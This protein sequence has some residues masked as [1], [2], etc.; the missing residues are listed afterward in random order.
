MY[1][2]IQ[3]GCIKKC[4]EVVG[5]R[6]SEWISNT[7]Q[8]FFTKVKNSMIDIKDLLK[9]SDYVLINIC[10]IRILSLCLLFCDVTQ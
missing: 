6:L 10:V 1:K 9:C 2:H 3:H 8:L 7:F 4:V 5:S